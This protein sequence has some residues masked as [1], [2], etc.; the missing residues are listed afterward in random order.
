VSKKT[1]EEVPP[2]FTDRTYDDLVNI[3]FKDRTVTTLDHEI[4]DV[5][6]NGSDT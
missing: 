4:W 3:V 1:F 2:Q 6:E 5:L